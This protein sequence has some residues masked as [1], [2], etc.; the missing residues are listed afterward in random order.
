MG[1]QNSNQVIGNISSG[2]ILIENHFPFIDIS[3]P[4]TNITQGYI[5][6][7]GLSSMLS[8][9]AIGFNKYGKIDAISIK[10]PG[11]N[12]QILQDEL[13]ELKTILLEGFYNN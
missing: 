9:P 6:N 2:T 7:K 11:L 3:Y 1:Y 13:Y 4:I 10:E 5:N 8:E 12:P